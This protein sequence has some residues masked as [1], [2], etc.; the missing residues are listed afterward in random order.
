MGHNKLVNQVR[1]GSLLTFQV[2]FNMDSLV[3][4]TGICVYM[5]NANIPNCSESKLRM[6][7]EQE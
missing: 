6:K 2:F 1:Y 7:E 5:L 4:A 3:F